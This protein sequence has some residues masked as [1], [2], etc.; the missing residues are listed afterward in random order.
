M[1]VPR[2]IAVDATEQWKK[3]TFD[4]TSQSIKVANFG[5]DNAVLVSFDGIVPVAR[6]EPGRD[7]DFPAVAE[8]LFVASEVGTSDVVI[9]VFVR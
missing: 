1:G 5:T 3:V 9:T 7:K 6:I 2:H 4:G 8:K